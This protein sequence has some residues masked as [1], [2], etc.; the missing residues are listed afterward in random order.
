MM[1]HISI[2]FLMLLVAVLFKSEAAMAAD[3]TINLNADGVGNKIADQLKLGVT[4]VDPSDFDTTKILSF[5]TLRC[6]D[7]TQKG[8][9][10]QQVV[11]CFEDPIK[12]AALAK[13][14]L[15]ATISKFMGTVLSAILTLA[16]TLF[17]LKAMLG[18]QKINQHGVRLLIRIG[19]V[20][21]FTLALTAFTSYA[22]AIFKQLIE[23]VSPFGF[24]PWEQIDRFLGKLLGYSKCTTAANGTLS[25]TTTSDIKDG[26]VGLLAGS[27]FSKNLGIM[28]S[29]IGCY[30]IFSLLMFVFQVVYLYL[31][32]FLAVAFLMIIAPIF[33]PFYL[34]TYTE[35]YLIKWFD[36]LISNMLTPMLMFAFLSMFLMP[37]TSTVNGVKVTEESTFQGIVDDIFKI[38][39]PDYLQRCLRESQPLLHSA[40]TSSDATLWGKAVVIS[41]ASNVNPWINGIPLSKADQNTSSVQTFVDPNRSQESVGSPFNYPAIDCGPDDPI[42]PKIDDDATIKREV[43]IKLMELLL[44]TLLMN[45]M[46]SRIPQLA[47]DIGGGISTGTIDLAGLINR[48]LSYAGRKH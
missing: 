26:I 3:G 41:N 25:C 12:N 14:G 18:E 2:I 47:S 42:T 22:F 34:F 10:V 16:I 30:T 17:G 8:K 13:N 27:F 44:F 20:L 45:A 38:L 24:S 4:N 32:S 31:A 46:L 48:A 11:E 1:R 15:I 37:T 5:Q 35:H 23:I 29:V 9:F 39:P 36:I 19:L 40:S 28:L 33:I 21:M 43:F 7:T 6:T